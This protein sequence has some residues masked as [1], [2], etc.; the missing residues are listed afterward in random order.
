M[1][2]IVQSAETFEFLHHSPVEGRG[3]CWTPS[4]PAAVRYG[5]CE[6]LE[7]AAQLIQDYADGPCVVVDLEQIPG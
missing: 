2:L 6:D 4:L 1:R 7:Q 3:V 5:I